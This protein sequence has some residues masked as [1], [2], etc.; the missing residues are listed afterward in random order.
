LS[1]QRSGFNSN[2]ADRARGTA[3]ATRP[4]I[5]YA[6]FFA[7]LDLYDFRA[8]YGD[9]NR[10]VINACDGAQ[11]LIANLDGDGIGVRGL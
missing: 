6:Q 3:S 7:G 11:D 5:A 8:M 9:L 2:V 10:S 4:S 1:G